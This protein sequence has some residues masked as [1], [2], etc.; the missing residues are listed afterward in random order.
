MDAGWG[1][2][3]VV[4]GGFGGHIRKIIFTGGRGTAGGLGDGIF[5]E[6]WADCTSSTEGWAREGLG[7]SSGRTRVC[8]WGRSGAHR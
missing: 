5:G 8:V 1:G 7:L 4:S 2:E 6:R 3:R